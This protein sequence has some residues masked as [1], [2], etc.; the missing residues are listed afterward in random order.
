MSDHSTPMTN[1]SRQNF[2]RRTGPRNLQSSTPS[3]PKTAQGLSWVSPKE[4]TILHVAAY[5]D[6]EEIVVAMFQRPVLGNVLFLR[7]KK[8]QTALTIAVRDAA[9]AV[10]TTL[11]AYGAD[12]LTAD[13]NILRRVVEG[14][15]PQREPFY[16]GTAT[17][18]WRSSNTTPTCSP[19]TTKGIPF[20][21]WRHRSA[22]TKQLSTCSMSFYPSGSNALRIIFNGSRSTRPLTSGW[23]ER[24]TPSLNST[25]G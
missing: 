18:S 12:L 19:R 1:R 9:E 8:G 16:T 11:M 23:W 10:I 4:F 22:T 3:C 17:S 20:C 6:D 25:T 13:M 7:N 24:Q 14:K 5:H 2:N 21:I 15:T